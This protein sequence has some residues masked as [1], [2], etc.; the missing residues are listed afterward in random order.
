[1]GK[2]SE[3]HAQPAMHALHRWAVAGAAARLA[4]SAVSDDRIKLAWQQD[5][6]SLWVLVDHANVAN[7]KGWRRIDGGA[8]IGPALTGTPNTLALEHAETFFPVSHGS[9]TVLNIPTNG[10]V[11]FRVG[12]VI[13]GWQDG[14]GAVVLTPAGGVTIVGG[15]TPTTAGTGSPWSLT[16]VATNT[17]IAAGKFV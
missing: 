16:K 9:N 7:A 3:R 12:T 13:G 2:H 4:L 1:M 17:W 8:T 10:T 5:D 15:G 14:A 11:P 6:G